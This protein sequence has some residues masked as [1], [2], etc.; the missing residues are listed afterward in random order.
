FRMSAFYDSPYV[1]RP[2]LHFF[3]P[4]VMLIAVAVAIWFWSRRTRE[5]LI[6]FAAIWALLAIA[7]VL[8]IRLMQPRDFVHIRFLYVPSVA[9]SLLGAIAFRQL[10]AQPKLR[11][12]VTAVCVVA[13]AISTRAQIGFLHD[14]EAMYLRGIAIAPDNPVPKNNLADDYVHAGRIDEAAALL[15][16]N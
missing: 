7:P 14:S 4:L 3:V 2:D 16:D 8:D 9:L 12:G 5:P 1:T 11:V 15:D 13:L 6:V 10:I